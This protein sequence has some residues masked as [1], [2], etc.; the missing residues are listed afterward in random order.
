MERETP[1]PIQVLLMEDQAAIRQ[2]IAAEFEP[3]PDFAIVGQA[4]S[5]AEAR[6]TLASP[7]VVILDLGLPDGSGADFIPELRAANPNARAIV[8]SAS[9][10]RSLHAGLSS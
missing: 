9:Y 8:L 6:E 1:K 7:D 10:D 4:S 3:E 2:A 5:L